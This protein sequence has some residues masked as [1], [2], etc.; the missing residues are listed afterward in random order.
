[1]SSEKR[2][3]FTNDWQ[4]EVLSIPDESYRI[5]ML[6]K[7][8]KH[9][10]NAIIDAARRS[11]WNSVSHFGNMAQRKEEELAALETKQDAYDTLIGAK[12]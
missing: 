12:L 2:T 7:D 10:R 6:K 3:T 8:I 1:M 5:A 9:L 4:V 11:Y